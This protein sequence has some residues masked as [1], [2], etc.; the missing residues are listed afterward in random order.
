VVLL[1]VVV[2]ARL[3]R[4]A[5]AE[6]ELRGAV[7]AI[8]LAAD[9]MHRVGATRA[10]SS[11]VALQLDRMETAL[12]DLRRARE[13]QPARPAVES[14]PPGQTAPRI[15]VGRLSQVVANLVDNAAEHGAGP[16]DVRWS[17]T[18]A[19]A[20]LEIRNR[21]AKVPSPGAVREAGAQRRADRG[22]GLGIASRAARDLGG[23]LRVESDEEATVATLELPAVDPGRSRAA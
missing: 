21:N 5:D 18:S 17:A 2:R 10:F 1:S 9:R 6:H 13:L 3:S 4:V 7:T 11:L 22:R 8:G 23:S 16:V 20:R 19:G 14:A 12:R 15:D